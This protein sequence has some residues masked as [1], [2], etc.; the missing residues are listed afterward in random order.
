VAGDL[1]VA[2]DGERAPMNLGDFTAWVFREKPPG[3]ELEV[4]VRR[5][6]QERTVSITT[7]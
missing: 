2:V 3:T 6:S 4:T 1:I 7:H 5:R